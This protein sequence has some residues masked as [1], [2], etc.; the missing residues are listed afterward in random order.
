MDSSLIMVCVL[1]VVIV[2]SLAC[3]VWVYCM[4]SFSIKRAKELN[5]NVTTKKQAKY[6]FDTAKKLYFEATGSNYPDF[7]ALKMF[8]LQ[9]NLLPIPLQGQ[10]QKNK[11]K[12][13]SQS[14]IAKIIKEKSGVDF[15]CA[16]FDLLGLPKSQYLEE[17]GAT[18]PT[19]SI[20]EVYERVRAMRVMAQFAYECS[21]SSNK[22]QVCKNY[23][24]M[25]DEYSVAL[26]EYEK[27]AIR[28]DI[29]QQTLVDLSWYAEGIYVLELVMG[30]V[31]KLVPPAEPAEISSW[32]PTKED[33]EK[34]KIHNKLA[35]KLLDLYF[36]YAWTIRD[37]M[38]AGNKNLPINSEIVFE[39]Y[40]AL[41][42]L[43]D[44]EG[45]DYDEITTDT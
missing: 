3:L 11:M 8:L 43:F 28:P 33:A 27:N 32:V 6:V 42:W 19:K 29:D 25:V 1:S 20:R 22:K 7:Y 31:E 13:P 10:V 26:T 39:R 45:T 44:E 37:Q 24:N 34:L 41:L 15:I 9:A 4:R 18:K 35:V 14:E 40:K 21:T 23:Q 30:H 17:Y 5:P 12:M 16:M 36:A 2:I 38:L